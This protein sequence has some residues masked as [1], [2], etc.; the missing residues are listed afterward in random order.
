MSAFRARALLRRHHK[1]RPA[2]EA[3]ATAAARYAEALRRRHARQSFH[4]TICSPISGRVC[5]LAERRR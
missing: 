2:I 5:R 3:M 4:V 1:A